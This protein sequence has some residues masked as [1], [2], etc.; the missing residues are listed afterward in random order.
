MSEFLQFILDM[1]IESEFFLY[2]SMKTSFN[3]QKPWPIQIYW[4]V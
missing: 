4:I 3:L 2:Y 1:Q